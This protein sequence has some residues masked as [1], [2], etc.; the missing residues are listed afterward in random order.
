MLAEYVHEVPA[1]PPRPDR[2]THAVLASPR[3]LLPELR[4]RHAVDT[5]EVF[6]SRV[7]GDSGHQSDIDVLVTYTETPDLLMFIALEAEP[8]TL[9]SVVRPLEV[10]GEATKR[11]P[12]SIRDLDAA[13]PGSAESGQSRRL[14]ARAS[15]SWP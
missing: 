4:Q 3:V 7:R 14:A 2:C 9:Y 8:K 13:I 6:G 11:E 10:I 15:V 5:L 1:A 12:A